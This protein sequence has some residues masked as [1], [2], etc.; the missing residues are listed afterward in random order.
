MKFL[1]NKSLRFKLLSS[2]ISSISIICI[3]IAIITF[4]QVKN[5]FM[6]E[7]NNKMLIKVDSVSNDFNNF[8]INSHNVVKDMGSNYSIQ[9]Y[10]RHSKS[11]ADFKFVPEYRDVIR[12]LLNV[13]QTKKEF[14]ELQSVYFGVEK[15]GTIVCQDEW[16]PPA[17]YIVTARDWYIEAKKG[18]PFT[19]PYIDAQKGNMII[20]V[21]SAIYNKNDKFVGVSAV[22]MSMDAFLTKVK[23]IKLNKTGY[24]F[25]V[26]N[27][28]QIIYHPNKEFTLQKKLNVVIGG[29][30]K[31][32]KK[33]LKGETGIDSFNLSGNKQ[34]IAYA[35]IK[36]N[37]WVVGIIVPEN[38]LLDKFNQFKF[39]FIFTFIILISI[40]A[41]IVTIQS[42]KI[43][44]PIN[45]LKNQVLKF[46]NGDLTVRVRYHSDDEIGELTKSFN[47]SIEAQ[48]KM[49]A[50]IKKISGQMAENASL[51]SESVDE[52]T[53]GAQ[54]ISTS[55]SQLAEGT[56]QQAIAGSD[57]VD[58]LKSTNLMVKEISNVIKDV[59]NVA[60][61]STKKAENSAEEAHNAINKMSEIK[62]F[63]EG[64]SNDINEL[65]KLSQDIEVIVDL[66]KGIAAQ[67]NLLALNAAIEAARA[68]EHGKGFAVVADEVK[69]L[70]GES[71][72][73]TDK[74]N[75]M[76]KQIQEK[77]SQ[78]VTNMN[79]GVEKVEEGVTLV[80]SVESDLKE[81]AER[82][83][84][85][86]IDMQKIANEII[87][88]SK[89]S[90]EILKMMENIASITEEA[91][92]ATEEISSITQAQ[93]M[94]LQRIN[95]SFQSLDNTAEN[96]QKQVSTF[97]I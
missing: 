67:T 91:A 35:P 5:M 46:S 58:R 69:K 31:I 57:G 90:D 36:E 8:F 82:T 17:D 20:T 65:G 96:L 84:V 66:I 76:I 52:T 44:N 48:A 64:I 4:F 32:A 22:D 49:V 89:N 50:E 47:N 54:Q 72:E 33:I 92:A 26:D 71:A 15:T 70:A 28:G 38:E 97:K 75:Y 29:S 74:I 53:L 7:V 95:E 83:N 1:E 55:V 56:Q 61:N 21:A 37:K 41:T 63:S 68:G 23:K 27:T 93:T 51:V 81:L 59:V 45:E 34:I 73:A 2:I 85:N 87:K 30:Q 39:I 40:L 3:L 77:T 14:G 25:I 79:S 78:A 6:E 12:T 80:S 42:D 16:V 9:Q 10:I 19:S 88:L 24:A 94:N 11:Q 62:D 60:N 86:K 18:N 13:K 43:L